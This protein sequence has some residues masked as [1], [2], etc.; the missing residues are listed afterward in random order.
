MRHRSEPAAAVR[1]EH[2]HWPGSMAGW[3]PVAVSRRPAHPPC[4][5]RVLSMIPWRR[6]IRSVGSDPDYRF[7]LANERTFLAWLRTG[8]ALVAGAV[9]L[10]SLVPDLGPVLVRNALTIALLAPRGDRHDRCIPAVG[11]SRT[12]VAG[13]P[14]AAYRPAPRAGSRRDDLDRDRHRRAGPAARRRWT[15]NETATSCRIPAPRRSEPRS[16]GSA[17]GSPLPWSAPCW[18]T[19]ARRG[20]RCHR[21]RVCWSW[22]SVRWPRCWSPRCVTRRRCGR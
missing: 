17:P 1:P 7:T 12:S 13:E 9:A 19:S 21:G 6:S 15:M 10:A 20:I 14:A 11:P 5:D 3:A 8:L 2:R 22:P 4:G 18:S 16:P